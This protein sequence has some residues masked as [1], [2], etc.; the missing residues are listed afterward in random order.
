MQTRPVTGNFEENGERE[1]VLSLGDLLEIIRRHLLAVIQ[2]V[3]LFVAAAMTFS[4][5]QMPMYESSIMILVG[6]EQ[7]EDLQ[8]SLGSD[9]Q[10]LEQLTQTMAEAVNSRPVAEAVI[11][12]LSLGMPPEDFLRNMTVEQ[13]PNTQ[14]LQ[15]SYTD[16]SPQNAKRIADTIGMVFSD[17]VSEVSPSAN[18]I[19]AT[20]WERAALLEE[21]VSPQPVRNGLLA[22]VLGLI[23]GVGLAFLLEYL[24]DSWRSPEEVERISGAPTFG[25]VPAFKPADPEVIEALRQKRRT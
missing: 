1:Y 17:Q 18:A 13:V 20:V 2:V 15:V 25:V 16:P 10:G 8:G 22:L 23:A 11:E 3:V 4:I 24:D 6:Q 5:V 19:T 14:F 21:P 9:V 7:R 12:E